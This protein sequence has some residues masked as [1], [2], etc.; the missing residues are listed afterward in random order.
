M[1]FHWTRCNP[2]GALAPIGLLIICLII[3]PELPSIIATLVHGLE[4]CCVFLAGGM[5]LSSI[6]YKVLDRVLM[7]K[8]VIWIR[9]S[10][11]YIGYV[12]APHDENGSSQTLENVGGYEVPNVGRI[13]VLPRSAYEWQADRQL[14]LPKRRD[15]R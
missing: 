7:P 8:H 11:Q 10:H 2:L 14:Q 1:G 15:K 13:P 5:V 4:W 12:E 9:G 3:A 6:I